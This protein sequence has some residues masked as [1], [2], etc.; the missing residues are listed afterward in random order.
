MMSGSD[1]ISSAAIATLTSLAVCVLIVLTQRWH[2]RLSLDSDTSGVQKFHKVPVPRI[3][4]IALLAALL[5][6]ALLAPLQDDLRSTDRQTLLMLVIAGL[7]AFTAGLVEDMT[8]KVSINGR[9]FA[10]IASALAACWLS[11]AVLS[12]VDVWGIDAVF[13]WSTTA[14]VLFTA[15]AVA[16]VAN[17]INIIDG[18][19]GIAGSTV[20]IIL[21]GL[22]FLGW[23]AGD[24]L[25]VQLALVGGAAM[26]GFLLLNYPTGRLFLGDGGAYL[27]GFWVAEVAILL[28]ARNPSVSAW[29]ALAVCAYPVIEALY[30]IYRKLVIRKKSPAV[31]DKLHL[32]MLVYRCFICK[33]VP[34]N[35]RLPWVRNSLV[36]VVLALW[37]GVS[38]AIAVWLGTGM[39]SA[40]LIFLVEVVVYVV[41]YMRLLEGRLPARN[42]PSGSMPEMQTESHVRESL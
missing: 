34:R 12:R 2:G 18:F 1:V 17:S 28:I 30:S 11:G 29:Q 37:T 8:K 33:L 25:V 36:A 21:A 20:I 31:P 6:V 13:Q 39:V 19:N 4:G 42:P 23:K 10:T 9:L 35:D 41:I 24:P 22:G 3:G 7:P 32:H 38:T 16:G 15:V 14:A 27:A 40:T 5:T 26:F